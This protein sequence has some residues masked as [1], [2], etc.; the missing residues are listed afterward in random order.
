MRKPKQEKLNPRE[1]GEQHQPNSGNQE[2][3][4]N[5]DAQATIRRIMNG[6][7]RLIKRCGCRDENGGPAGAVAK[8]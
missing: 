8:F 3:G 4:T 5:P 2:R 7:V 6:G 1:H